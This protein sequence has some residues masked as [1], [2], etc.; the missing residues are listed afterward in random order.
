[1]ETEKKRTTVR[2]IRIEE[3]RQHTAQEETLPVSR[4]EDH[5]AERG[6]ASLFHPD[7]LM[8][9]LAFSCGLMLVIL[10]LRTANQPEGQ[11]VFSALETGMNTKWDES[12][13]KLSFVT[14]LLPEE[15][16]EVWVET[17]STVVFAPVQGE[18]I[19]TWSRQ[20]PYIEMLGSGSDVRA[21]AD[22]EI[23]SIAHGVEE[24]RIVRIRHKD[25]TEALYGNLSACFHEVGDMVY[26]G[27]AF[28]TLLEGK[29]LAFEYR[30][31]GRSV[32][33]TNGFF[34]FE[35]AP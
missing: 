10:A 15:I 30:K 17:E 31:N 28:A 16:Q 23:M 22:G 14:S 32:E 21:V 9:N 35:A 19:H 29:P 33:V 4:V 1:M 5:S 8:K 13:G 26:T 24:E 27:D 20:E 11:T 6:T 2:N 12:I 18:I 25:G 3:R 7:R 34:D